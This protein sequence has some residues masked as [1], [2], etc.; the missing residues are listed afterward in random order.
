V[1]LRHFFPEQ[2]NGRGGK[3]TIS[4]HGAD[5]IAF[6]E[7]LQREGHIAFRVAQERSELLR[8]LILA[9]PG[10]ELDASFAEPEGL[11]VSSDRGRVPVAAEKVAS[12]EIDGGL[13]SF[14]ESIN[15]QGT[16]PLIP[17]SVKQEYQR[18]PYRRAKAEAISVPTFF[19]MGERH[20]GHC[21]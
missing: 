11:D 6:I 8:K 7:A 14:V 1:S 3:F 13:K 17:Q 5:V 18:Q 21:C 20:I 19:T 16:R 9:E 10:G 12:G 2:W 4:Q 15:G